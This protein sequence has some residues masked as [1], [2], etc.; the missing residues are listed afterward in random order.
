MEVFHIKWSKVNV[1]FRFILSKL[2]KIYEKF[3][4]K[5]NSLQIPKCKVM[6]LT[7]IPLIRAR[8]YKLDSF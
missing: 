6:V 7:K 4:L 3:F 2:N 1:H 5:L 8:V